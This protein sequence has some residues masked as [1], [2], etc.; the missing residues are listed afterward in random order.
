MSRGSRKHVLDWTSKPEFCEEILRLVAP[1]VVCIPARSKWMPRGYEAAAE[2]R[3]ETFGP[4]V[5]PGVQLWSSLRT[6]WLAHEQGANTP[7]WDI[8]LSCEVEGRP[9]L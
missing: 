9:G 6:W 4:K 3:L 1:V 8:A 5:L 7:N 2:A